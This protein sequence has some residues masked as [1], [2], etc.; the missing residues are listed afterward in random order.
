MKGKIVGMPVGQDAL[1]TTTNAD[2]VQ[3]S[4]QQSAVFDWVLHG[5]GN[6]F[7]EAVAGSGKT[8][9]ITNACKYMKGSIAFS[10]F[11]KKIADEIKY[12]VGDRDDIRV[13]TFHS[14]GFSAWRS[15]VDKLGGKVRVDE[16]QKTRMMLDACNV[17]YN[18]RSAVS[19]LTSLAKQS[20]IGL[21]W[22]PG[23]DS[24]WRA[25][26]DHYDVMLRIDNDYRDDNDVTSDLIRHATR[27]LA[28][29]RENGRTIVDFDDML[30]LPLVEN[31]PFWQYD[32]I[33]VDEAQ[34]LNDCR[35]IIARKMMKKDGRAIFVGD[36][37][38]AIYG[39]CHTPGTLIKT[40]NGQTAIENLRTGDPVIVSSTTGEIEGWG[41][42]KKILGTHKYRHSG[43]IITIDIDGRK[44][45][46]TPH[47]KI[48][49]KISPDFKYFTYMMRRVGV[50]RVGY[51]QAYTTGQFMLQL[52]RKT[53]NA[54]AVWI[55]SA[56]DNEY[57][58]KEAER[59]L[60][61]RMKGTT[62][63]LMDDEEVVQ[64]PTDEVEALKILG[65]HGRMVDFPLL[66]ESKSKVRIASNGA[67]ITEACNLINGMLA[68]Y[69][70]GINIGGTKRGRG[71]QLLE[72]VPLS[73]SH[74]PYSGY[75]YGITVEPGGSYKKGSYV[76]R[77]PPLYF[78]G[79]DKGSDILVHNTGANN[80]SV[81]LIVKEFQCTL[82]PLTVTYRCSKRATELAQKYVPHIEAH[83]KNEEGR[84][85]TLNPS[86]YFFRESADA[87][88]EI[89]PEYSPL[90][91]G[92][93]ILCRLTRPLV[94]LAF[95]LI[96]EGIPCHVEGRDIGKQLERLVTK[97]NVSS[98]I[99][100]IQAVE[101][102]RVKE[103]ERLIAKDAKYAIEALNDRIDTLLVIAE[104][105]DTV[106]EIRQ[107]IIT[108]FQDTNSGRANTVLLS[109]IHRAKGRE[110]DRVF[111]L[112][113]NVYMPSKMARKSWEKEQERNLIYVA[114]TR[115]KRDLVLTGAVE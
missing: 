46:V 85:L 68:T 27:C 28:W 59:R 67:F 89:P 60:L 96:R 74:R 17:P 78:A 114:I 52:R 34:D 83:E 99:D 111:I 88:G 110:W 20:A 112:G 38:Q 61:E 49:V 101:Q 39:F 15:Y 95:S 48:P 93:A 98:V 22:Y 62:F 72:W 69:Y 30:W 102:Y 37:Y 51:C 90:S 41:G 105:C 11:N 75:V 24:V 53:E 47:H 44:V 81:D 2:G 13:G 5:H 66:T 54:D 29:A 91:P 10:A 1:V 94:S 36:R 35:R 8:F 4:P 104:G 32:W 76:Q 107:K 21:L 23:Q 9:T 45:E 100:L 3:Y 19:H 7:V 25:L 26:I 97:W 86:V 14:F 115:T 6:A 73:V 82:L 113:W 106:A 63:R 18:M 43:S 40:P 84:V 56:F 58:A 79:E 92:D 12:K 50:Y 33:L 64:L 57:D 103:T 71:R 65:E 109:T 16:S 55:L 87:L 70:S 77:V 108:M 31:V 42:G 80:D